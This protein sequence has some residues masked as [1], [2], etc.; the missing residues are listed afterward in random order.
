MRLRILVGS[1]GL[2]AGLALYVALAMAI[3]AQL[4]EN[5]PVDF[6]FYALAGFA[7]LVPAT[8]LTRWMMRAA[9]YRPPPGD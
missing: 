2:V 8:Y 7:W 3:A 9:P 1:F 6:G 5:A 4:P